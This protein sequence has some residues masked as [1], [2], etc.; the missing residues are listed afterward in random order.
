VCGQQEQRQKAEQQRACVSHIV[1]YLQFFP[2]AL[3]LNARRQAFN[4]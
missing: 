1:S 4:P 2:L 3:G